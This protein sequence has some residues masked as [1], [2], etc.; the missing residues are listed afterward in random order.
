[1]RARTRQSYLAAPPEE[2]RLRAFDKES[3][4]IGITSTT[5]EPSKKM[6]PYGDKRSGFQ[7]TV[8]TDNQTDFDR[9]VRMV[10]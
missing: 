5:L 8:N 4:A 2:D 10:S 9:P 1:M 7:I 3:S 6:R